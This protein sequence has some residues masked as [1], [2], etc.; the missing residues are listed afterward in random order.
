MRRATVALVAFIAAIA[1]SPGVASAAPPPATSVASHAV[2]HH[3]QGG[4]VTTWGIWDKICEAF[5]K[6]CA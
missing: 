4:P 5:P 2:A 6:I 3:S 1:M